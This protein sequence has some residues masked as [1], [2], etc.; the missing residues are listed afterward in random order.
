MG[1]AFPMSCSHRIAVSVSRRRQG[2]REWEP[3]VSTENFF[4]RPHTPAP[5]RRFEREP[6]NRKGGKKRGKKR[7]EALR[8]VLSVP[9][10]IC[11]T[12]VGI[13]ETERPPT[14][15][16]GTWE[17]PPSIAGRV[18]NPEPAKP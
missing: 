8:G 16:L 1:P 10:R 18:Q 4:K 14:P 5:S 3:Q 7:G 17:P 12:R 13:V 6:G 11:K 9:L 15:S 2:E